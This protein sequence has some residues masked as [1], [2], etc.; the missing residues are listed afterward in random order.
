M[1]VPSSLSKKPAPGIEVIVAAHQDMT[2]FA[3]VAGGFT[4]PRVLLPSREACAGRWT[5][6]AARERRPR[7]Q[8]AGPT[9]SSRET[10]SS[11]ATRL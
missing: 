6:G 4:S 10:N 7:A 8:V 1:A 11:P 2:L 5:A 3:G 9:R